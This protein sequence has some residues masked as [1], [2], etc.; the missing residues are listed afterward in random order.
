MNTPSHAVLN[1]AVL[2][3]PSSQAWAGPI[4]L[5]AVLPDLPLFVLYL[6]AKGVRRLPEQHIWSETYY[7]PFW[8]TWVD[9]FHSIPLAI[10][11]MVVSYVGGFYPGVWLCGSIGLHALLDLPVHHDDAHR[12]F[13]PFH[14]FRFISPVSYWDPRHYG[15]IAA[16]VEILLV[17]IATVYLFPLIHA[18]IGLMLLA[19]VNLFYLGTYGY[20]VLSKRLLACGNWQELESQ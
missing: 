15:H 1:L 4:L 12:H 20:A 18:E 2:I 17:L 10:M 7:H 11:G 6:W 8:Q 9:L 19:G 14:E 16:A 5:G 13:F 3:E